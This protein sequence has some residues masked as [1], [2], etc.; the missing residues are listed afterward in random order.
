MSAILEIDSKAY[1][2]IQISEEKLILFSDG[3]LGFENLNHYY[4]LD[5]DKGPFYWLQSRDEKEVAFV[6]MNPI[7]FKSDYVLKLSQEDFKDIGLMTPKE[8]ETNLLHFVIVTIPTN[9][10]QNMTA[11]LLGPIIINQEKRIGKQSLSLHENYEVRHNI[12]EE[13]EKSTGRR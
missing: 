9:E 8:V 5:W 12:L 1:G 13:L 10:A 11:N 3:I 2:R 7:F 6:V 4:I